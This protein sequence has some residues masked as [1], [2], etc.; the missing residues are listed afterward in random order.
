M[1]GIRLRVAE[2]QP[3]NVELSTD[4]GPW[5]RACRP[6]MWLNMLAKMPV[7]AD[8]YSPFGLVQLSK[9]KINDSNTVLNW[10]RLTCGGLLFVASRYVCKRR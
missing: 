9:A 7:S 1:N 8:M 3:K 6:V 5:M 2:G 10:L 4:M